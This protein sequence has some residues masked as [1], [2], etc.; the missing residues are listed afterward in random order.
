MRYLL[1]FCLAVLCVWVL[2]CAMGHA[3]SAATIYTF[4]PTYNG[5]GANPIG[6]T[7]DSAG[8]LYGVAVNGGPTTTGI[9]CL[10]PGCGEIYELVN[11]GNSF[12]A[13]TEKTLY[14][15]A[16]S[17]DGCEPEGPLT[18]DAAGNLYG[19]QGGD[20]C[21]GT[22]AVFKLNPS[23]H[24][25]WTKQII[26][27]GN[28]NPTLAIDS[29]GNLYGST[30]SFAFELLAPSSPDGVW[31]FKQLASLFDATGGLAYFGGK[32]YGTEHSSAGYPYGRIFEI[33]K[34]PGGKGT[35]AA[36]TI[37]TFA[38]GTDGE[39]PPVFFGPPVQLLTLTMPKAGVIF[40]LT[41]A[42][43]YELQKQ[44]DGSWVKANLSSYDGGNGSLPWAP[45]ASANGKQVFAPVASGGATEWSAPKGGETTWTPN[46]FN[47]P[48]AS[49][50]LPVGNMVIDDDGLGVFLTSYFATSAVEHVR[51]LV[52]IGAPYKTLDEQGGACIR[53]S[54]PASGNAVKLKN[55]CDWTVDFWYCAQAGA[56]GTNAC[57]EPGND[58]GI[59][60]T[61]YLD[62]KKSVSLAVTLGAGQVPGEWAQSC[63]QG[64]YPVLYT[65]KRGVQSL[66]CGIPVK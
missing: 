66:D 33:A 34:V 36:T 4:P 56:K 45:T 22:T 25:T 19:V 51:G 47:F 21:N 2:G 27:E 49:N 48:A 30:F 24:G 40:G 61:G 57:M 53:V 17:D 42:T 23:R 5:S 38:G 13:W 55:T 9:T 15:F 1:K 39:I 60:Q 6:L 54:Y 20:G 52:P 37:A 16:G 7:A 32:L 28:V 50:V 62:S 58:L 43:L 18:L 12:E 35:W 63:D 29:D 10:P 41:T 14:A 65:N 59:F 11:P 31:N 8:N 44:G 3:Q 26:Y 46:T 64:E